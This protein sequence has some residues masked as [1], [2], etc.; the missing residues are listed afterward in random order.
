MVETVNKK[1]EERE[2]P[3]ASHQR[4]GN[5]EKR[6]VAVDAHTLILEMTNVSV[7]GF[8]VSPVL[9]PAGDLCRLDREANDDRLIWRFKSKR[10][11][12]SKQH[13]NHLW[14]F[15]LFFLVFFA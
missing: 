9:I 13:T 8:S 5:N 6:L 2:F 12:L 14:V 11:K 10:W 15:F 4:L 3:E 7:T 1:S